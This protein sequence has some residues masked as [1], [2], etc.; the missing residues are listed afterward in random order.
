MAEETKV[1]DY[2]FVCVYFI[3][4]GI[5]LCLWICMLC[6]L[7]GIQESKAEYRVA[8]RHFQSKPTHFN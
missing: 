8:R 5:K 1:I 6:P 2:F 7:A 3:Y 4:C